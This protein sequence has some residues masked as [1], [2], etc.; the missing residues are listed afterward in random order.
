[1]VKLL[2]GRMPDQSNPDEVL[3]SC[4]SAR[5]NGVRVGSVI[6]VLT[7]TPAQ[8]AGRR[9]TGLRRSSL[10]TVP[11]RSLRVVGLV[12]TENEFPA[13]N[14]PRYDLFPTRRYAAATNR[15]PR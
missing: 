6:Q 14:G 1:M 4:T 7:P 2:S 10:A 8:I 11:R 13:G 3:A 5:D 9:R 15:T 12:V